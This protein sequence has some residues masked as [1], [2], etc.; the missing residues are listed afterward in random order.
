M[1]I[2]TL[3]TRGLRFPEPVLQV[4]VKAGQMKPGEILQ[5]WGDSQ[6]FAENVRHWCERAGKVILSVESKG[7]STKMIR[8]QF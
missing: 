3:D 6:N 8:I 5:V 7:E 1:T 2:Q 4:V